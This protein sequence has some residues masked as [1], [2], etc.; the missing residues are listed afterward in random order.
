MTLK[1]KTLFVSGGSR[2]VGLEIAQRPARRGQRR[3]DREDGRAEP[4]ARGHRVHR[5]RADRGRRWPRAADRPR[6]RGRVGRC[7]GGRRDVGRFGG[8]DAC[9]NNASAL[10]LSGTEAL[11]MS[12]TT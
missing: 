7:G 5:G 8:I 6:H 3:A 10:N 1:D 12:A 2:G 11:E 9:V 4:A